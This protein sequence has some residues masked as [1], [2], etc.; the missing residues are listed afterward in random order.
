MGPGSVALVPAAGV[1]VR[2]R[3]VTHPFRQSSD[4][5]Y[6]TGLAEP[7]ALLALATAPDGDPAAGRAV[8]FVRPRDPDRERWEGWRPGPEGVVSAG[9]ADEAFPLEQLHERLPPLLRPARRLFVALGE[10]DPLD[11]RVLALLRRLRIQT[12]DPARGPTEVHDLHDHLA[13]LRLRKDAA[14]VAALR[15]AVDLSAE[16]LRAAMAVARPGVSEHDLRAAV[17]GRFLAGGAERVAFESVVAAGA[18]AT[19]LHYVGGRRRIPAGELVIVDV[20]AEIDYLA[21]D[22]TRTFPVDGRFT[23]PQ[24]AVYDLVRETLEAATAAARPG[25]T[26]D[27]LH[28]ESVRRL[29]RGMIDLGLLAG[30][31][32]GRIED[33]SYRRFYPHRLGHYLGMDVH[34]VGRYRDEQ[35]WRALAP[36]MVITIEPGLYVPPD[37]DDVPAAL[38]GLGV[39]IEDDVLVTDGGA[40]N[41][42]AALPR[43]GS[44]IETLVGGRR[45]RRE[46]ARAG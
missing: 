14:E 30:D 22:L 13:E 37:A 44:A 31:V 6:L 21:G 34:D 25:V 1:A 18:N 43:E 33:E 27:E 11:R 45:S 5:W 38:R 19:V 20:G 17:E 12:R 46:R 42:S 4:F 36:G 15:R 35:G 8:L 41:L 32:D 16:G 9:Q 23:G 40:E 28:V 29:T 10:D 3:D 26:H 24:R 7:E 2:N 39:R